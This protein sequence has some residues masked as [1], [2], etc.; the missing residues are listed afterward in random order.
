[1]PW[2][3]ATNERA[4]KPRKAIFEDR[5]NQCRFD[6]CC[7]FGHLV[8]INQIDVHCRFRS[9]LFFVSLA[10]RR[11]R[12]WRRL[13]I[14]PFQNS[15][16]EKTMTYHESISTAMQRALDWDD[17]PEDLFPLIVVSEAANLCATDSD[18]MGHPAWH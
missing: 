7:V 12:C 13:G 3:K 6:R 16:K 9:S 18:A 14:S 1:V 17:L 11:R 2:I 8:H 5:I 4:S 10:R 15:T